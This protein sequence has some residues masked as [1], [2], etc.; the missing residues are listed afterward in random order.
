MEDDKVIALLRN[1]QEHA[2]VELLN[3]SPYRQN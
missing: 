1:M 3:L 2:L